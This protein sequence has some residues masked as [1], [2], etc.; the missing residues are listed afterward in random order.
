MKQ[1]ALCHYYDFEQSKSKSKWKEFLSDSKII[2]I[3]FPYCF[4]P[5]ANCM[6]NSVERKNSQKYSE[7]TK[8]KY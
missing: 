1:G 7:Y 2:F 8:V 4:V 5:Y 3:V 6:W